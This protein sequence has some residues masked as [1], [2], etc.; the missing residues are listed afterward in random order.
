MFKFNKRNKYVSDILAHSHIR[1]KVL[2]YFSYVSYG[3]DYDIYEDNVTRVN[4]NPK[5]VNGYR[6]EIS[7]EAL[8]WKQYGAKET[9]M[10][11]FFCEYRYADWFRKANKI[12]IDGDEYEV[13][14]EN[15]GNRASIQRRP[16]NLMRVVLSKR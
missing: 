14:R 5:S 6:S 4:M 2:L 7:T 12:E 11:E 15:V 16:M 9:G 13:Y 3:D 10:V 1:T 8:T